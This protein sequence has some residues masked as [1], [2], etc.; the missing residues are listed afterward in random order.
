MGEGFGDFLGVIYEDVVLIIGYGKVCVGEW[1]V[2]VYF[3]LDLICL[4]WL[5]MNKVYLK[6]IMNEVYDDGEIWV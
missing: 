2:I 5:D 1:D 6:D 4:C 3:S